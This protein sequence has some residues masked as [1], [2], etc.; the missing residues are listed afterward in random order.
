MIQFVNVTMRDKKGSVLNI[1][2]HFQNPETPQ[3]LKKTKNQR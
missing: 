2:C 3:Q 1:C